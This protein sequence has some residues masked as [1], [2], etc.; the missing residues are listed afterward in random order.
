[1]SMMLPH[2]HGARTRVGKEEEQAPVSSAEENN[3]LARRFLEAGVNN[4][5]ETLDELLAPDFVAW[6][7]GY[8]GGLPHTGALLL[9]WGGLG[10]GGRHYLSDPTACLHEPPKF[11]DDQFYEL[12]RK[13]GI[14]LLRLLAPRSRVRA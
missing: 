7:G 12:E 2:P 5:L 14:T 1:M 10:A 11:R 8:S 13:K 4:D 3:A 6:L 9:C